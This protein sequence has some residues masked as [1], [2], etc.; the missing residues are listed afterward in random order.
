MLK[1]RVWVAV[2]PSE[3]SGMI[4]G[5]R[6]GDRGG[7]EGERGGERGEEERRGERRGGDG[8]RVPGSVEHNVQTLRDS[9]GCSVWRRGTFHNSW[10]RSPTRNGPRFWDFI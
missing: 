2:P 8:L 7:E 1:G 6:G 3:D 4:G 10:W 5:W 9:A